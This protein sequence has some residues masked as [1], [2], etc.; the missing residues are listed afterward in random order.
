L[1]FFT[2]EN[3]YKTAQATF[4][5]AGREDNGGGVRA[6]SKLSTAIHLRVTAVSASHSISEAEPGSVDKKSSRSENIF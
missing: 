4:R 5:A 6:G 1:G 2:K 3:N